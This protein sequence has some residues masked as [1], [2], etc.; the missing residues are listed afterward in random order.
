V[1]I[2]L[3][4]I[5]GLIGLGVLGCIGCLGFGFFQAR[6]AIKGIFESTTTATQFAEHLKGGRNDQAYAL[7]SAGYKAKVSK[8]Q[9]DEEVKKHPMLAQH[10]LSIMRQTNFP[11]GRSKPAI[12]SF[13][14]ELSDS[15][16]GTP[17]MMDEDD[18]EDL[19]PGAVEKTKPK[20]APLPKSPPPGPGK[21]IKL[22]LSLIEENG[23]WVIDSWF[24]VN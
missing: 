17:D 1:L 9:F 10:K 3:G 19:R 23:S 6:T 5:G 12:A 13:L 21:S 11:D 4:I 8:E 24:V 22:S 15:P 14:M 16:S 20:V 7:T 18:D 2:V